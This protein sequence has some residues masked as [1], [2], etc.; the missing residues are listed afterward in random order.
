MGRRWDLNPRS[1]GLRSHEKEPQP[2]MLTKLRPE[3][4]PL[5]RSAPQ[6]PK[7]K[8]FRPVYSVSYPQLK[9]FFWLLEPMEIKY[10]KNNAHDFANQK[11]SCPCFELNWASSFWGLVA[12]N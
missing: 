12:R 6:R 8:F 1:R 5:P 9:C 11:R 10:E 7:S 2:P 4:S 3:V